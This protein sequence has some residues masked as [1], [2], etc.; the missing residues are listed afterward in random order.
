MVP[1]MDPFHSGAKP[2]P[3]YPK[4][5]DAKLG[6]LDDAN[7][8]YAAQCAD[9]RYRVRLR[10][11]RLRKQLG[12]DFQLVSLR[13]RLKCKECGSKRIIVS[14]FNPSHKTGSLYKFFNETPI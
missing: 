5:E 6:Q 13:S 1:L 8:Y 10:L 7:Y 11:N 14:F 3:E 4:H 12:D 2:N 9:C